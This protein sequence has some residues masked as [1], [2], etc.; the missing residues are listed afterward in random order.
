MEKISLPFDIKEMS[1]DDKNFTFEGHLAAFNNLD[2]DGD[3]I[4]KGAFSEWLN[5]SVEDNK[6]TIPIFWA[7]SAG[8]PVGVFPIQDMVEDDK[9]LF[10]RGIMPKDD[11]FVSGRV[12]PQ[13]R[14]G[15]VAKMSIGY[16]VRDFINKNGARILKNI[17]LWEGSLVTLPANENATISGF[18][19]VTPYGDLP[20]ANR[21]HQWMSDSAIGRVRQWAGINGDGDL[22]DPDVQ[23][24]YRQAFFWY[25][26]A[27]SDLFGAYK[28][29]FAD[30]I[31][32]NL[33]AV[34]R[35]IFAAA[36][37]MRGARGGVYL[38]SE[39]RP[40]IINNIERYYGKMGMESPFGKSI[41]RVDDLGAIDERNFEKILKTG[42]NFTDTGAKS[43]LAAIKSVGLRDV[44]SSGQRDVEGDSELISKINDIL[45]QIKGD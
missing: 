27:D 45:K 44:G 41:F 37:A 5:K 7:H 3:I 30:V 34:P 17:Q 12:I 28:L 33:M 22:S 8:E 43:L 18:K 14:I 38:P 29:P 25:D 19:S 36:G 13:M 2:H 21:Q 35:G 42:V 24:K 40:A 20:L 32:G 11:T 6:K 10:V 31:N 15:S 39:E 16:R 9:G 26:G 23:A 4:E 1:T